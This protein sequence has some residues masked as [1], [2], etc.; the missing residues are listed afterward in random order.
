M[1]SSETNSPSWT[2]GKKTVAV[3]LLLG[4]LPLVGYLLLPLA[5]PDMPESWQAIHLGMSR[6]EV[7]ELAGSPLETDPNDESF[8]R[9]IVRGQAW[10][11]P[12]A[13]ILK[14]QFADD[15]LLKDGAA[16]FLSQ[17]YGMLYRE[18]PLAPGPGGGK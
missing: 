9:V 14:V 6:S 7:S 2:H 3:G 15:G 11:S 1:T 18:F 12:W 5:R 10:F 16:S 4:L 13:W 17:K 8:E